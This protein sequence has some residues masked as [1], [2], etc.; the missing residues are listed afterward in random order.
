M[1][2]PLHLSLWFPAFPA[3]EMMARAV[4][5]LR[6][7]PFSAQRPGVTY[8]AVHPV[9]WSEPTV[10]EQRF[11]P[12]VT[13]EEA[14]ELAGELLHD[15]YAYV[16]EM[17]WDLWTPRQ[18]HEGTEIG[19]EP[20]EEWVLEPSRVRVA[21]HGTGFDEGA[22]QEDG[23]IEIEFGLDTPFLYEDLELSPQGQAWVRAN[24]QK[25]L[26]LAQALGR[27]AGLSGRVL[28]SESDETLAQ[29]L[30]ARLQQVQ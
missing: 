11:A 8:L 22:F 1:A 17:Y 23:H 18:S 3:G 14:A 21:V 30:I 12:G 15:D 25:L 13:P 4:S 7:F 27:K 29:K 28:W 16:F 5:V 26:E 10:L 20:K 24:V 19:L 9:A 2:D 6:H